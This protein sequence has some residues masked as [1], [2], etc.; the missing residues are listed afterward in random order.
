MRAVTGTTLLQFAATATGSAVAGLTGQLGNPIAL[1]TVSLLALSGLVPFAKLDGVRRRTTTPGTRRGAISQGVLAVWRSE[2]I[3]PLALLVGANGLL[4]MGPYI[5]LCPLI[6]RDIYNGGLDE[7]ATVVVALQIGTITGSLLLLLAG[8]VERKGLAFLA[9]L[10]GVSAC[11]LAFGLHPPFWAFVT[12]IFV[13]GMFHAVFFNTSR[14]LFQLAAS[15]SHRARVMSV[16][17]LA[18]LG[19]APLSNLAFGLIGSTIG[20]VAG[21]VLAG[22]LMITIVAVVGSLTQVRRLV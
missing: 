7:L 12:L 18:F 9:A 1:G 22:C 4:F 14:A 2:R 10:V 15:D 8:G 20:P 21:C 13:W 3:L 6:V 19:R 11:L 16:H 17:A 5:V